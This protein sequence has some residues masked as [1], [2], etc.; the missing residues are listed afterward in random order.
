MSTQQKI[1]DTAISVLNENFSATFED[2]AARCG[3]NR[4]TLHRYFKNRQELLE[5]CHKNMMEAWELAAMNACNRSTDP[6]IQL[7]YLLYAGIDSGTKY[8][9]LIKLNDDVKSSSIP[10]E[11][12]QN[13]AYC[14][15]R[16]QL[17]GAIRDLQKEQV[18]DDRFPLPW[19]RILFTSVITATIIAFRSGD[20]AQNEVKKLAWLSF[21]RSIGIPLNR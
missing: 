15:T 4:R 17:F 21:S 7:E 1:I 16:N 6:L 18:I 12:E 11:S 19:I 14:K 9:F 13:A 10:Y 3:I 2:I 5:A 8:A 20:I